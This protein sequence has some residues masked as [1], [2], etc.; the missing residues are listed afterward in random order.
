MKESKKHQ[1]EAHYAAQR[2]A[3]EVSSFKARSTAPASG[4][5]A[6]S[7]ATTGA[8]ATATA[9][10]ATS[11]THTMST[12]EE[13]KVRNLEIDKPIHMHE[14]HFQNDAIETDDSDLTLDMIYTR[15][16]HLREILPI[17]STLRQVKNKTAPL[18][19][20]KFLNPRP[21]LIDI[22]S[23]CDFIAI[24]PIHTVVFDN[25]SLTPEMFKIVISSLVASSTLEKL[26]L[27]NV[28][29]DLEGWKLAFVQ[30]FSAQ[31]VHC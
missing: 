11:A 28:V 13:E 29:I 24:V 5:T 14:N 12:A 6:P 8:T 19:T 3:H 2:I 15:C 20:L 18:Q 31:P 23:F 9:T 10:S 7:T 22:L 4:N 21:T 30:V 27:R 17:P 1:Q 25:V 16:C 26:S